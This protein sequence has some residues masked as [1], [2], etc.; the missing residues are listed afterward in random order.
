[1]ICVFESCINQKKHISRNTLHILVHHSRKSMCTENI[2]IYIERES[3]T[4]TH[5]YIC[6]IYKEIHFHIHTNFQF[7]PYIIY[8]SS[9][10]GTQAA[11]P[12]LERRV[13]SC[14]VSGVVGRFSACGS[15]GC[16][17]SGCTQPSRVPNRRTLATRSLLG[18]QLS[19]V[20]SNM[21][22]LNYRHGY[23]FSPLNP[24]CGF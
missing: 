11:M 24:S 21:P 1:M 22:L 4:H 18:S 16:T 15:V 12:S 14:D 20:E 7:D 9:S 10:Q 23:I 8:S 2:H 19:I 3:Q 5:I 13:A 6:I 17:V